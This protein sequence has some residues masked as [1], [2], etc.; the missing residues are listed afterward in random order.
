MSGRT[1]RLDDG[2]GAC[3]A[4]HEVAVV[5]AQDAA[6]EGI[7]AYLG[8]VQYVCRHARCGGLAVCA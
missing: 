3:R 8:G 2:V 7:A 5:V 1:R 6:E 4:E